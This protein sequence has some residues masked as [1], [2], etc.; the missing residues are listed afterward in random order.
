MCP[1]IKVL[2]Q[3]KNG[4]LTFCN[5]NKLFQLVF[6]NLCFEFYEWELEAFKRHLFELNL[7]YWENAMSYAPTHRKIPISVG[8]KCFVILVN[9]EEISELQRLLKINKQNV[10]LITFKD[11]N[12][13]MIEN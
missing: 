5:H 11:I 10:R 4:I 7:D 13:R 8:N 12:Y 6:N 1:S 9:Q 3:S 2:N